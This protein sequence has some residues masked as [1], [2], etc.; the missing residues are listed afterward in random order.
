MAGWHRWLTVSTFTAPWVAILYTLTDPTPWI[1]CSHM[2][3]LEWSSWNDAVHSLHTHT[4]QPCFHLPYL[5]SY[6]H[7]AFL[8][9]NL[10]VVWRRRFDDWS[11]VT[12][13]P[14]RYCDTSDQS[15]L[16]FRSVTKIFDIKY[17]PLSPSPPHLYSACLISQFISRMKCSIPLCSLLFNFYK[18]SPR[19]LLLI[20]MCLWMLNLG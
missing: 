8:G 19:N 18:I 11:W 4:Q 17:V 9:L 12:N 16:K 7:F 3:W 5:S 15:D 10:G 14:K 13:S 6:L 20:E 2:L 1:C